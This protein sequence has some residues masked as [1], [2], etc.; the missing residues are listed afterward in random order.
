MKMN[1]E[2]RDQ[3]Y[4]ACIDVVLKRYRKT[5]G[6]EARIRKRHPEHGGLKW[7][8]WRFLTSTS[9]KLSR[10]GHIGYTPFA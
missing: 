10:M 4:L 5:A 9:E 6:D 1:A 2:K 3:R 8:C 7:G